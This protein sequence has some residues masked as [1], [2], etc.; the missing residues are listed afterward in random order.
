MNQNKTYNPSL[1]LDHLRSGDVL[2]FVKSFDGSGKE[3]SNGSFMFGITHD[4]EK[5]NLFVPHIGLYENVLTRLNKAP[6]NTSFEFWCEEDGSMSVADH[7]TNTSEKSVNGEVSVVKSDSSDPEWDTINGVKSFSMNKGVSLKLAVR[8]LSGSDYDFKE[9]RK[10]TRQLFAVLMDDFGFIVSQI[11]DS[12][13]PFHLT[14]MV[15]QNVE[16]WKAMLTETEWNTV[17]GM[18]VKRLEKLREEFDKEKAESKGKKAKLNDEKKQS[19]SPPF[20]DIMRETIDTVK[21]VS[22]ADNEELPF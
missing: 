17:E 9:I 19:S 13:N 6:K 20:A 8:S 10:R 11:D 3:C 5:K 1:N 14:N 12:L 15:K 16:V 2:K 21:A 4:E 22:Q 18:I 7:T